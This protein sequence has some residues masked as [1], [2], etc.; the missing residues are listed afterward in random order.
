MA[1][2]GAV[3]AEDLFAASLAADS[4][5]WL[6][7]HIDPNQPTQQLGQDLLHWL[8]QNKPSVVTRSSGVGWIAVKFKSR[9]KKKLDAKIAWD[10][11]TGEKNNEYVDS[12]ADQFNIKGGKWLLHLPRKAVDAAWER[13]AC[14]L[15]GGSLGPQTYMVKVSP[16][17]DVNLSLAGGSH[18]LIVYNED[19]RNQVAVRILERRMRRALTGL[20]DMSDLTYKPDIYSVLGIYRGNKWGIKPTIYSSTCRV[21]ANSNNN[22]GPARPAV[23]RSLP[24]TAAARL[25]PDWSAHISQSTGRPYYFNRQTGAKTWQLREVPGQEQQ[26]AAEPSVEQLEQIL[27]DKRRRLA[28]MLEARQG[29]GQ[30]Q[31]RPGIGHRLRQRM[32]GVSEKQTAPTRPCQHPVPSLASVLSSKDISGENH[33]TLTFTTEKVCDEVIEVDNWDENSDEEVKSIHD[34]DDEDRNEEETRSMYDSGE[35]MVMDDDELAEIERL[36]KFE[37]KEIT[38]RNNSDNDEHLRESECNFSADPSSGSETDQ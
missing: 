23:K 11:Y 7:F 3:L 21:L 31:F 25:P 26:Q 12:L 19:Y 17:E 1:E 38:Q 5:R 29:T 27:R 13:L 28:E 35:D 24:P 18:V 9:P 10:E 32:V 2:S 22:V 34:S 36:D 4:D 8:D 16:V 37:K 6:A 15:L 20:A 30:Q 14:T 33:K